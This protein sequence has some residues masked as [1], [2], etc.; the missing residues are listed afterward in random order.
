VGKWTHNK[1]D[2]QRIAQLV[3]VLGQTL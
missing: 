2:E 3:A 1:R